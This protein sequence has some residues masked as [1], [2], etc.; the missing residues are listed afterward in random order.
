MNNHKIK[1]M[2]TSNA[3]GASATPAGLNHCKDAERG[4]PL[5]QGGSALNPS[6]PTHV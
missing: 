3:T 2:N 4:M 1:P 5:S 6:H